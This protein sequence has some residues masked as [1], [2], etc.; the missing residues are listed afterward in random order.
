MSK[1]EQLIEIVTREV[2]ARIGSSGEGRCG[3]VPSG[4]CSGS[5]ASCCSEK[6]RGVVAAG[7]GRV[8]YDGHG[9]R[10]RQRRPGIDQHD[11]AD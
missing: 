4:G 10:L 5:C 6:V 3:A 9:A 7:A 2:L 1:N 8:S 11:R